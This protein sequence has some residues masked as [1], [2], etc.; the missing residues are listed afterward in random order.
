MYFS[1]FYLF[2]FAKFTS[3]KK[4]NLNNNYMFEQ[5]SNLH[6]KILNESKLEE[7]PII[8]EFQNKTSKIKNGIIQN[9]NFK[10]NYF[11]KVRLSYFNSDDKQMFNS[12][13]YPSYDYDCPILTI[14]LVNFGKNESL[15]FL[16]LIHIYNDEFYEKK[17]IYPLLEIKEKYKL[18]Y[19]NNISAHLTPYKNIL[20]KS[21]L[22]GKLNKTEIETL[23][24]DI[25]EKY[26]NKYLSY[27]LKKPVN[28]YFIEEK[29]REYNIFRRNIESKYITKEYFDDD[30]FNRLIIEV[31]R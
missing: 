12:V 28:R 30:W 31:N 26:F 21:F 22:Y 24:P 15:F 4:Y 17:Y 20:S 29:H 19:N 6:F 9:H 5:T 11:R 2:N 7:I 3:E 23:V 1:L 8:L 10:N 14:D 16:N 13:W 27:F 25:L 18:L